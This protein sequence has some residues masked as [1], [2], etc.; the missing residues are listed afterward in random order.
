MALWFR[1]R[2]MILIASAAVVVVAAGSATVW[3]S[4]AALRRVAPAHP[5]ASGVTVTVRGPL[6][7][8]TVHAGFLGP[9]FEY[10]ALENYAGK[11]P[12]AI[13]SV[14]VRLIRNL[15]AG[16]NASIRIGGVTTDRVWWPATGVTR[17]PG[18]GYTITRRR[19]QVAKALAADT[20]ARLI[21]GVQFEANSPA[22]AEHESRA[23]A[24]VIGMRRVQ[25]FELGNEPELYASRW[26]YKVDG[27]EFFG[28]PPDWDFGR[29]VRDYAHIARSMGRVP[30]AGPAIGAY[31]W[32]Q[33][34]EQ[35]LGAER[36]AVVTLHRY[37]LQACGVGPGAANYPT[38]AHLLGRAASRGLADQFRPYVLMVHGHG[39]QVRNA[40][41]NSVSCGDAHGVADTFASV[42]WAV[43]ALF[44]IRDGQYRRRW[45]QSPHLPERLISCSL[46]SR[47]VG[48]GMRTSRPSTT[49]S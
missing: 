17:S 42:L 35:F 37:P 27:K 10:W 9:S 26:F 33:N 36:V 14:L 4:D 46:S 19:L 31:S 7:G 23:M 15:G 34:L 29:F 43:D 6:A 18:A 44:G 38:I 30:L 20:G 21:L 24:S 47:W 48:V 32:M 12:R 16:Q 11:D 25:A 22:E 2:R 45:C 49:G 5:R 40:E 28:R 39:L 1:M 13:D 8:E 3:H 41:M